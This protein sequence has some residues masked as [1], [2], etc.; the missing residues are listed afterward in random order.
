MKMMR[1]I[2]FFAVFWST[3][4]ISCNT[5]DGGRPY[6]SDFKIFAEKPDISGKITQVGMKRI[7][8]DSLF[9]VLV[10][11]NP[12]VQEPNEPEGDKIYFTIWKPTEI[13]ILKKNGNVYYSRK[14][15]LKVGQ[16]VS[17]WLVNGPVLTSYPAQGGAKRILVIEE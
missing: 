14:E 3:V 10:E 9:K 7:G 11:E 6:K 8:T 4:F 12:A 13:F 15:V 17:G 5:T 16:R 1:T 2:L